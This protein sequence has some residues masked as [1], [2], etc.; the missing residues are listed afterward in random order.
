MT[1]SPS[2]RQ[3]LP[4][5]S[6]STSTKIST[7]PPNTSPSP[8]LNISTINTQGL[9]AKGKLESLVYSLI[10][11]SSI[12]LATETK[13]NSTHK[14]KNKILNNHIIHSK[15]STGSKN[16]A[17]IILGQESYK[18]LQKITTLNE[19]WVAITLAFK[20]STIELIVVYLPHDLKERKIATKTLSS[21]IKSIKHGILGGDFNSYPLNNKAI[22]AQTS[23]EK[24]NI[25][26]YL[27][28][29]HDAAEIFKKKMPLLIL[30]K[31]A[32]Q[33]LIKYGLPIQ[34]LL[35]S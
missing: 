9:N 12:I 26:N 18:H 25:Y 2:S 17:C 5:N 29:W 23:K 35:N 6:P 4:S 33:R 24:R 1:I 21:H 13:N 30:Q 7:N 11:D 3:S 34:S 14:L 16:G 31:Q 15:P 8:L 28:N 32:H 22:N 20:G 10:N 27:S 19:Y